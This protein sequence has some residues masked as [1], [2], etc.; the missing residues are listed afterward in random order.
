MLSD[1][2]LRKSQ[3]AIKLTLLAATL[4]FI[5]NAQAA[6]I[7]AETKKSPGT[8]TFSLSGEALLNANSDLLVSTLLDFE[9][10]CSDK[11]RCPYVVDELVENKVIGEE[12]GVPEAVWTHVSTAIATDTS[13]IAVEKT[14]EINNNIKTTRVTLKTPDEAKVAELQN[15][16]NLEHSSFFKSADVQWTFTQDLNQA[17]PQT[18]IEFEGTFISKA[19]TIR[20]FSGTASNMLKKSTEMTFGNLEKVAAQGHQ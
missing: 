15:L 7:T 2:F 10:F 11:N 3:K 19:W 1:L 17:V 9:K 8:V 16:T 13:F 12:N 20:T 14:E 4:L 5:A 18:Q 6:E